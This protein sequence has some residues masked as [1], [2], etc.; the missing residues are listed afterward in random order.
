MDQKNRKKVVRMNKRIQIN[1]ALIIFG[2]ILIYVV[3]SVFLSLRK[4]PITTYKVN[5]SN[6]NNN[7][8]C[9]GIALRQEKEISSDKSGYVCYFVRDG[10]KVAK[11][12]AVCTVDETG[13][14]IQTVEKKDSDDAKF[15]SADYLEIRSTIDL[16]KTGYSDTDFYQ[17]YTFR[18][19]IE[20]KVMEMANQLIM[21]EYTAQG[22]TAKTTVRNMT[23][24][25]SGIV[26]YYTDGY[27]KLTPET[28]QESDFDRTKYN[29]K[30]L[31]SG[32]I[33]EAG[34]TIYKL[35]SSESWNICCY[36]TIDQA[37]TLADENSL[38]YSIN[39][40][41]TEIS[42]KYDMIR[43]ENGYILV[44]PLEKYMIDYVDERFLSVEIIL[45]RYEGLKV[46]NT[47]IIDKQVYKI[48]LEFFT[49]GGNESGNDKV[50]VQYTDE[51]GNKT[52]KDVDTTIYQSD[53]KF[54]YVDPIPF[55]DSDILII[56]D[57]SDTK[58]VSTLEHTTLK[59]VY[60]A[61]KGVADF[62]QIAVIKEGEEFT[63]VDT[64]NRLREFDNIVMDA[65]QV[66][67]NQVLY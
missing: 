22:S 7:I 36:I 59:G 37:N 3:A 18:D 67:E 5:A 4:E 61:N 39:N 19:N 66:T 47:A 12:S 27:E 41:D 17:V 23:A 8:I 28:L 52:V 55:S 2:I 53:E 51:E 63:I 32:E 29:R 38:V 49:A 10:D 44:L 30:A 26:T 9:D 56:P 35:T 15:S 50:Y 64:K 21:K 16:F 62:S 31:K 58:P 6:I 60:I 1:S 14:L 43:S 45:D 40:S 42:S 46:P 54:C 24:P 65:S 57:S 25:E 33:I 11:N 34:K 20:S 13:N 48:P